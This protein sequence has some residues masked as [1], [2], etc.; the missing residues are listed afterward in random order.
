MTFRLTTWNIHKGFSPLN[1]R[2]TVH[3]L[4]DS[5][6]SLAPDLVF[7]QEVQGLS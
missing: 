1:R 6:R 4:R 3:A 5:L 2:L 7:L